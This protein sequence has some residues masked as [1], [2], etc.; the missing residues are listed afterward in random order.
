MPY[1]HNTLFTTKYDDDD[2]DTVLIRVSISVITN[3]S[4]WEKV[5]LGFVHCEI[6]SI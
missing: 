6:S 1:S 2:D 5:I 4:F 3:Q